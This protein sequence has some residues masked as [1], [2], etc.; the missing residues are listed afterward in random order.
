MKND[1]SQSQTKR[2]TLFLLYELNQVEELKHLFDERPKERED[3]IVIALSLDIE[4]RLRECRIAHLSGCDYKEIVSDQLVIE[5]EMMKNFFSNEKWKD[6]VYRDIL[7][8]VIFQFMFRAYLQRVWYYGNLIISILDKHRDIREIRVFPP[9]E[10]IS[11][12][13]GILAYREINVVIDCV[14]QVASAKGIP[15]TVVSLS[16]VID[17]FRSRLQP[18]IFSSKRSIFGFLLKIW[19]TTMVFLPSSHP[20]MVISDHWR[21]IKGS[22]EMLDKGKCI[23]LDRTEINQIPWKN[24]FKYRIQFVHIEDFLSHKMRKRAK[25]NA[26]VFVDS[27]ANIRNGFPPV[28]VWKGYSFDGLLLAAVGDIVS[29][30]ERIFCEIEGVYSLYEKTEADIVMLRAS[31]SGQTHFSIL[32]L[33]AERCGIPSVE[34]QHG[35][36]YLGPGSWSRD[37]AA[38]Y[39]AVYGPLVKKEFISLGYNERRIWEIGSPRFDGRRSEIVDPIGEKRKFTILCIAP[40]IRPFE[41]YDSYSAESY[42]NAIAQAVRS[43]KE[44]NIMIKLRPGPAHETMLRSIITRT[45]SGLDYTIMQYE[46][47]HE[48]YSKA[49]T[50]ISCFSTSV[51]EA[52][53]IGIPV[54]MPALNPIDEKVTSF[55]FV[56]YEE[57]GAVSIVRTDDEFYKEL[58]RLSTDH[59]KYREKILAF[60]SKNFRFDGNSSQ[61]YADLI[62]EL[63]RRRK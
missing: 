23:F 61:R 12:T 9:I 10:T 51:L 56:Q 49:D 16:A 24:L 18:I 28:F 53:Q 50:V 15:V 63:S 26:K 37:H 35:I 45:F 31:V 32:P 1:P 27:W 40:D 25:S 57:A 46:P 22:I 6:F 54:I 21:N 11:K 33:V 17:S 20:R 4:E 47:L 44:S 5:D 14:K 39:I 58:F 13:F 36:E 43:I 60:V 62:I 55:H 34:L 41:I 7:L 38:E 2:Q 19:N 42:F 48:L 8:P 3:S 59:F 52:L 29:S 30:F